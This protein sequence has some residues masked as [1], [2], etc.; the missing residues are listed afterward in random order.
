MSNSATVA[1]DLKGALY[2]AT[3]NMMAADADTAD[4]LVTFG[5]PGTLE[6]LDLISFEDVQEE[7]SPATISTNRT[8]NEIIHLTVK[9]SCAR[10]GGQEME[11]ICSDRAYQL[12]KKIETYVRVTDTTL[13]GLCW[14]CFLE[15]HTSFGHTDLT[16]VEQGRVIEIV[17]V[18]QAE[19]RITT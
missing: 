7:Q 5:L 2:D 13:G 3:V 18:F 9:I 4:V 1:A 16:E 19:A 15:R 17:A 11:R 12:L 8:R 6:P 10:G 14:W